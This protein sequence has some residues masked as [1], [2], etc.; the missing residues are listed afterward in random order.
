MTGLFKRL[1]TVTLQG[2]GWPLALVVSTLVCSLS[3]AA[4]GE[5]VVQRIEQ[6]LKDGRSDEADKEL[7]KALST[8][9]S[10]FRLKFLQC[11][12]QAQ[13]GAPKKGLNCFLQWSQEYPDVPEVY[14]N[15]GVLYA[16]MGMPLEA[17]KWLEQGLKQEQAYAVLHQNLL[18]LQADMNRPAYAAALQLDMA[19]TPAQAKLSLLARITSVPDRASPVALA[20]KAAVSAAVKPSVPVLPVETVAALPMA[21]PQR[22]DTPPAAPSPAPAK[23]PHSPEQLAQQAR[24]EEAVMAWA[25]AWREKDL[26]AYLQFYAPSFNPGASLSRSAWEEQRRTRILSKKQ[27]QLELSQLNVQIS[28]DPLKASVTFVQRY[29]SGSVVAASRKKLELL[30]DK[31]RWQIVREFVIGS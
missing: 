22:V 28:G 21:K 4:Q 13:Q 9:G 30:E 25:A 24:I 7:T 14:N 17:R 6:L 1:A 12:T 8:D 31:G 11:V 26:D 23:V 27:I 18:N 10:N 19:K 20:G 5:S 15:I 2:I 16:G 29:E 3:H